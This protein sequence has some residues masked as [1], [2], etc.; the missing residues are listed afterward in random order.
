[1]KLKSLVIAAIGFASSAYGASTLNLRNFSSA[2][3]GVPIVDAG[4]AAL[5]VGSFHANGGYFNTTID[6]ATAN[7][8]SIR[9]AFVGIDTSPISGGTRSGLF[10]GQTFNGVL[11]G[12]FAGSAAYIVIANNSDFSAATLFAVFNANSVFVGPDAFGNSAQ[13]L[14]ALSV[15][16]VVFGNIVRV[17]GQPTLNGAAFVSGVQL[18]SDV[19]PEPSIALLGALG[20]VGFFRRKR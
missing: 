6:W 3:V 9:S 2:S 10:T 5:E 17:T 12:G 20:V 4:G 14:D 16:N 7:A 8:E 13:T 11:P 19:I 1:M 18:I 15:D